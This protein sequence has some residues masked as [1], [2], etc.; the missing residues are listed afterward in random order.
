MCIEIKK[1]LKNCVA[2]HSQWQDSS[3]VFMNEGIMGR[4]SKKNAFKRS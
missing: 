4:I 1:I 2:K 3:I